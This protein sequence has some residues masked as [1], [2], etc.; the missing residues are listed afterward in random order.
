MLQILGVFTNLTDCGSVLGE[1]LTV[2]LQDAYRAIQIAIPILVILLCSVDIV[3]AV[4]AQ[5][6]KD[7][8]AAQAKAIKRVI[9]GLAVLFV[10]LVLDVLFDLVGLASGTCNIGG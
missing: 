6:D 8:K 2:V 7:M 9:I 10:P 4:V 1:D 3:R 5:D